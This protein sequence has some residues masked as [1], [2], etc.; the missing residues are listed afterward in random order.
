MMEPT[1]V[2]HIAASIISFDAAYSF[3][4]I[5][6]VLGG[7]I[8][9]HELGHFL[10][11]KSFNVGVK[12]FSLGFGPRLFGFKKGDT[13]YQIAAFPLG[14]F[15][16]MVG[17]ADPKDIPPPFSERDSFALRP[18]WQRLAIIMAGPLFNLILAWFI[19]WGLFYTHGQEYLVPEVGAVTE[20]SPAMQAGVL[21]GDTI[22][23][24]NGTAITRWEEVVESVMASQGSPMRLQIAR[25]GGE[26][27]IVAT[28]KVFERKTLFGETKKSWAIG[29]VPSGAA[30]NVQ[31]G[32]IESAGQ[33]VEHA[34]FV[35]RLIGQS[36]VKMVERVVPLESMGGPIRI[37][38]EIHQQA[39]SGSLAGV[40][41]LAAFI[42]LNLGLLNLLPVP[43]LDGGHMVFILFEML[44][45]K[46]APE[47]LQEIS[48][49]IGV[50][51]LLGLM[52]FVTYNDIS[53]WI[54]GEL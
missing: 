52:I 36:I 13:E 7:L 20:N 42:S 17:E 21:P 8:F 27:E 40:L 11:A 47:Q 19:Y 51:L 38:K 41:M 5:V 25:N 12:T 46:P 54:Q 2:S 9:F 50:A 33:G 16:S 4:I 31:F 32:F 18:A 53:K 48:I 39:S 6:L 26:V 14:G 35:T 43:V 1:S 49:R 45:G 44:R 10:V 29:I 22:L 3:L 23:T 24:I 30:G 34:V 37:A 28:P 15:V